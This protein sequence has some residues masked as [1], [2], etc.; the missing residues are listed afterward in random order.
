MKLSDIESYQDAKVTIN[1]FGTSD[2]KDGSMVRCSEEHC[3]EKATCFT[4]IKIGLF[5][6]AIELCEEHAN[7]IFHSLYNMPDERIPDAECTLISDGEHYLWRVDHCPY[8]S[9]RHYH[10]G[11]K[12]GDDPRAALGHR[13]AHCGEPFFQAA[14]KGGG[15]TLVEDCPGADPVHQVLDGCCSNCGVQV[16]ETK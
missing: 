2:I 15:Y 10:G 9:Q 7:L 4:M 12:V 1:Y 6:V 16:E 5:R 8:C 14:S 13:V 3:S 11:G